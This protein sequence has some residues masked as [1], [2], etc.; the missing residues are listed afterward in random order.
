[1]VNLRALI[2]AGPHFPQEQ[3]DQLAR[4]V[5]KGGFGWRIAG[6]GHREFEQMLQ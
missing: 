6:M 2:G 3:P 4:F 1:M 5:N